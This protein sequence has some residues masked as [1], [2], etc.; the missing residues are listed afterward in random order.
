MKKYIRAI[1]LLLCACLCIGLAGCL[2]PSGTLP[3]GEA[4]P[5]QPQYQPEPEPQ[6]E[7]DAQQ[8]PAPVQLEYTP[9]DGDAFIAALDDAR[10]R[11]QQPDAEAQVM[12]DYYDLTARFVEC[13][14]AYKVSDVLYYLDYANEELR[15]AS[16]QAYA[17]ANDCNDAMCLFLS[18]L[19]ESDYRSAY[20]R[21]IGRDN[22]LMYEGYQPM[23]QE[24][25]ELMERENDLQS[26]YAQISGQSYDDYT[27]LAEA[28]APVYLELIDVRNAIAQSYGYDDY[29]TY[30]YECIYVRGYSPRDAADLGE[31]VK[32]E[33][34]PLYVD[35][36]LSES[37]DDW[38]AWY[39]YS[40]ADEA[41]LL[42]LMGEYMPQIDPQLGQTLDC[43]LQNQSYSIAYSDKKY[44]VSFT[45][46]LNGLGTPY[47]FTQP[48]P[49]S[50]VYSLT[51]LVHEFGHYN[52][53][54]NDPTYDTP[55]GLLYALD[56]IDVAEISST[57]LELLF[58]EYY[59]QLYGED[60]A[61]LE[62]GMLSELLSNV[63][64]GC[65]LDEFQQ[66]VYTTPDLT[67]ADL[68]D[69]CYQVVLDYMGDIFY[70]DYA[71]TMWAQIY[72]N[73]EAPFYYISYGVSALA[74][75]QLWQAAQTDHAAAVQQYMDISARGCNVDFLW[76]LEDADLQ[77]VFDSAYL[78]QLYDTLEPVILP[79]RQHTV[80][81]ERPG[82]N[83]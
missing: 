48:D 66:L 74:S 80:R 65:M 8:P 18:D 62:R 2:Q 41:H 17:T 44:D 49:D 53:F 7:Q 12:A 50:Q 69:I 21:E 32:Q 29:P 45:T 26:R 34:A 20:I 24:Q 28:V 75:F 33:L 36:M 82:K 38:D 1:S 47:L 37:Q 6:P 42:E 59:P 30:A 81:D 10:A 13:M 11:W 16:T 3:G 63:V 60:A 55:D 76:L 83:A 77:D 5:A 31:L 58:T 54:L 72:H 40:Q 67:A 35:S 73:F 43:M 15:L 51:T 4:P 71:S 61:T 46:M 22:A 14:N 57:G 64:Y 25:K 27:S 79:Q 52:N 9:F 23:T 70:Q 56:D 19:L 68:N 78:A 39:R